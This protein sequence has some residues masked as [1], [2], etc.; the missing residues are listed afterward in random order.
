VLFRSMEAT[1]QQQIQWDP[2]VDHHTQAKNGI[3][4]PIEDNSLLS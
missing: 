4:N 1:C 2:L 3:D